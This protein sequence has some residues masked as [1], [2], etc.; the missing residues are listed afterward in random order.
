M[1]RT[2]AAQTRESRRGWAASAPCGSRGSEMGGAVTEARGIGVRLAESTVQVVF[3]F[4]AILA[5]NAL[6]CT[7]AK[8]ADEGRTSASSQDAQTETGRWSSSGESGAL[9]VGSGWVRWGP[10]C[11]PSSSLPTISPLD[12]GLSG[13]CWRPRP[14][15]ARCCWVLGLPTA[16]IRCDFIPSK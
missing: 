1:R 7:N 3:A 8:A 5:L 6:A 11:R 12:C 14:T 10:T 4:T 15:C 16:T 2:C 9:S 13:H